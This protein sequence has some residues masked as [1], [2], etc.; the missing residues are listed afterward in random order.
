MYT[1]LKRQSPRIGKNV[2]LLEKIVIYLP[3]ASLIASLQRGIFRNLRPHKALLHSPCTLC[4]MTQ[5]NGETDGKAV[6]EAYK[7]SVQDKI[8]GTLRLMFP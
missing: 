3:T 1:F 8:C 2:Y 6:V 5:F 4:A 7:S